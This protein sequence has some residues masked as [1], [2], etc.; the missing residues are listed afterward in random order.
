MGSRIY[1]IVQEDCFITCP[2]LLPDRVRNTHSI[3]NTPKGVVKTHGIQNTPEGDVKCVALA[4]HFLPR[5]A[6]NT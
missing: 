1:I 5:S 2:G 4:C 6:R 3:R